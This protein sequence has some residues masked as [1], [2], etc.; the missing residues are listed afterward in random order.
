MML[1]SIL[2]TI[3]VSTAL[4]QE[5]REQA[6]ALGYSS[7]VRY[8]CPAWDQRIDVISP[9]ILPNPI[10]WNKEWARNGPFAVAHRQ[11]VQ[12]ARKSHEIDRSFC[13]RPTRNAGKHALLLDKILIRR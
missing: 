3:A 10:T 13:E 1:T 2:M 5:T 6:W 7:F 9:A 8:T 12:S 4:S 11:G